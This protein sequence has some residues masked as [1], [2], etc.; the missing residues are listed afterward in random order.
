MAALSISDNCM[1]LVSVYIWL[2]T[3]GLVRPATFYECKFMVYAFN[4]F[5]DVGIYLIVFM[6]FDR[7]TAVVF[8][9]RM[10]S[11]CTVRRARGIILGVCVAAIFYTTAFL[12]PSGIINKTL[13]SSIK[14][15][16]FFTQTLSWLNALVASGIPFIS[17]LV[18]NTFIIRTLVGGRAHFS[19][20][21]PRFPLRTR[22]NSDAQLAIMLIL[23]SL[24]LL[25]LTLPVCIRYILAITLDHERNPYHCALYT[26]VYH[27]SQKLYFTNSA[28]NF[29]LYCIGGTK[30][31]VDLLRLCCRHRHRKGLVRS[32]KSFTNSLTFTNAENSV[33]IYEQKC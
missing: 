2:M 7:F 28:V 22:R 16:T 17:L 32:S 33:M 30:F 6:T 27:L 1:M 5:A 21:K 31:R 29:Y 8:P 18:M 23:V 24:A 4:L 26:F 3:S 25:I 14:R 13:C 11:V 10:T 12:Y 9:L 19:S 20:H 15:K